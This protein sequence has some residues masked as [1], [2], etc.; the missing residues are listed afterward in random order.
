MKIIQNYIIDELS[1]PSKNDSTIDKS[2][3][4]LSSGPFIEVPPNI[5]PKFYKKS[6]EINVVPKNILCIYKDLA[7]NV[8]QL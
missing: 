7:K 8:H 1:W 6:H 5:L 3:F 2:L 4:V